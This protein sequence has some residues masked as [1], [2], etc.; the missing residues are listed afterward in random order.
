ML[1]A[2]LVSSSM[3][4]LVSTKVEWDRMGHECLPLNFA[5]DHIGVYSH[6][7]VF[8]LY[9]SLTHTYRERQGR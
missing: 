1:D 9:L 8:S 6:I 5:L 2:S 7:C 4:V 3:K